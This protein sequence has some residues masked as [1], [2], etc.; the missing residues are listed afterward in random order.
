MFVIVTW[1]SLKDRDSCFIYI[2]LYPVENMHSL[3]IPQM[4]LGIRQAQC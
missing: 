4:V 2:L 1:R 3:I